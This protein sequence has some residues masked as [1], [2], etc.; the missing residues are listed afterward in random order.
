MD[1]A[2]APIVA[3]YDLHTRLFLNTLADVSESDAARRPGPDSN[4]VGF[5]AAHLVDTRAW[6]GR[7]LGERVPPPFAGL[8]EGAKGIADLPVLPGLAAIRSAW[9]EV[10]GVVGARLEALDAA[11]LGAPSEQ[12]FP[13]VPA[14]VLGGIAFLVHHEAYHIGQLAYLRKLHGAAPMSYR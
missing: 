7:F 8:L 11:G 4:P 10:T 6:M 5:I 12:R 9:S 14:T 1:A 3:L 13:G 2:L